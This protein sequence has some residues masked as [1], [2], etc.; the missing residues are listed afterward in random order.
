MN[1]LRARVMMLVAG[2]GL[3]TALALSLVMHQS[4]RAYYNSVLY[5]RSGE[6]LER[7]LETSPSLWQSYDADK[8]G[9]SEALQNY[10]LYSPNTG[11]YL[12]DADGNVLATAGEGKRFWATYQVD[13]DL[14]KSSWARDPYIPM[15]GDDPDF[16]GQSYI[17]ALR[18]VMRSGVLH[19]WLYLVARST[20]LGESTPDLFKSYAIRTAA[21]VGLVVLTLTVLLTM[22]MVAILTKPL[23]GLT[24]EAEKVRGSAITHFDQHPFPHTERHDEIGQLSRTFRDMV[25]RLRQEMRRVS[26]TDAKRREMVASVSHDLRTPLTALLGQLE[27][28]RLK[29]DRLSPEEQQ[30]FLERALHNAKHLQRLTDALAELAKLDNPDFSMQPE[31]IAIGELAGDVVQRY[32]VRAHDSGL[33]MS[34]DYPDGLPLASVDAGLVERALANLLDNALR[35][36]PRGGRIQVLVNQVTAGIRLEVS[37]TGPGVTQEDRPQLFDRFFQ[38]SQHRDLRGSAGLGL[39]IVKR[40]AEL[41]GGR[42]GVDSVPGSGATFYLTLPLHRPTRREPAALPVQA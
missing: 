4:V 6:F 3:L 40:V 2:F 38:A 19:G 22:A 37:D 34:I 24:R 17:V 31:P 26:E 20:D 36:T 15:W 5:Q 7:V 32:E 25:G 8:V 10:I 33:Q 41:H 11:L 35:V 1:S 27:T 42:A 23:I 28:V 9:F 16:P 30:Q 18:P 14:M 29:R 39:A 21:K 13:L 12:L